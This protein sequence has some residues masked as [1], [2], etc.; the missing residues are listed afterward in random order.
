MFALTVMDVFTDSELF[1]DDIPHAPLPATDETTDP[2]T[3]PSDTASPRPC[4][5]DAPRRA[6]Y[7]LA[8]LVLLAAAVLALHVGRPSPDRYPSHGVVR[9]HRARAPHPRRQPTMSHRAT[10]DKAPASVVAAKVV[11]TV[12]SS[13]PERPTR[14]ES[15]GSTRPIGTGSVGSTEQFGYLGR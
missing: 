10:A 8:A 14:T 9:R 6:V 12:P 1:D 2:L 3:V 13:S 15:V 7:V 5:E 11:V 4:G